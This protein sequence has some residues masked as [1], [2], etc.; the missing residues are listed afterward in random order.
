MT[1]I[2]SI[3]PAR[4]APIVLAAGGTGGHLFPAE[5]L[6]RALLAEGERVVLM[7]DERGE[8]MGRDLPEIE[9]RVIRS[10]SPSGGLISKVKALRDLIIGYGQAR[11]VLRALA[12]DAVVGFGG[13]PSAPTVYA[14]GRLKLPILLHEQN[15]F[16][17]RVN[18]RL[19]KTAKVIAGSFP[20]P[21]GFRPADRAKSIL[22]GNPV[23]PG[24]RDVAAAPY[25]APM[26][27]SDTVELL[28]LGGSQG[29]K[30]LSDV[31]P[32]AIKRL[33]EDLR[34]RIHVTQQARPEDLVRVREAYAESGIPATT[35]SFFRNVPDL[36][37]R[38]HL[39]V[40]RAGASTAAELA[41]VG[42]PAILVPYPYAMDDH[43]TV[44]A[45]ALAR[46]G[47]AWVVDQKEFTGP[48]LADQ[49][50]RLLRK[51]EC[52]Q[53]AAG[54]M[55]EAGIPDADKRLADAVRRLAGRPVGNGNGNGRHADTPIPVAEAAE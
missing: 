17:G 1:E 4:T 33:P 40:T 32:D 31:V 8:R 28:V 30:V 47:G 39:A 15:A 27:G 13:Y 21:K 16:A 29:A 25:S 53:R 3:P 11:A 54:A 18:R 43:Q 6:A 51:P 45:I 49:I 26:K 50:E 41:A 38:C 35:E 23:R 5:A 42:R 55:A 34:G 10:A 48:R 37:V 20:D 2:A 52:L 9:V 44:N 19:G 7:T 22:T 12:P 14:A 36:L 24:I 46:Q